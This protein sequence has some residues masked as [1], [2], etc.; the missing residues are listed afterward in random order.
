MPSPIYL[1]PADLVSQGDIYLNMPSVVVEARPLRVARLYVAGKAVLKPGARQTYGVHTED[2]DEPNGGFHWTFEAGG[3]EILVR[4]HI[5]MAIVLSHDCE[6]DKDDRHRT[7]A[8]VRPLI[9]VQPEHRDGLL[10]GHQLSAFPLEAQDE[11]PE[12][13]QS[14]VDFRRVTTVRPLLLQ[15]S[16]RYASLALEVR[17]ALAEHYWN[18]LHRGEREGDGS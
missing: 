17:R 18:Y 6:I 8:I 4:A 9:E 1:P 16:P 15:Q 7:L 13:I 5:T 10:R 12:M 14:F 2:G 11:A 3:E